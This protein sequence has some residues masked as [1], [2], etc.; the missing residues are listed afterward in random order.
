[1]V[2]KEYINKIKYTVL[3]DEE[4]KQVSLDK[5]NFSYIYFSIY[6]NYIHSHQNIQ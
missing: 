1:M 5:V 3:L 6:E 4:S 2:K